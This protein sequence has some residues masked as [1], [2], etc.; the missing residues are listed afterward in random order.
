M[1]IFWK[2]YPRPPLIRGRGRVEKKD[3]VWEGGTEEMEEKRM[4]E[5]EERSRPETRK[6]KKVRQSF[7][8][9]YA[10]FSGV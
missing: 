2:L 4:R 6:T 10:P 9:S 5:R 8:G 7:T 1:S 3:E